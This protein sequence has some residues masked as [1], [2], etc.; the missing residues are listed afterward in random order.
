[1]GNGILFFDYSN[2]T[3]ITADSTLFTAPSNGLLTGVFNTN[4]GYDGNVFVN[5]NN[6]L[7]IRDKTGATGTNCT[8]FSIILSK[9]DIVTTRDSLIFSDQAY[10]YPCKSL[11]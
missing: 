9:G 1:M 10:F 5:G 11:G 8:P 2:Q 7:R 3:K 6:I 4:D